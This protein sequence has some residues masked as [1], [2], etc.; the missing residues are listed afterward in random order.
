MFDKRLLKLLPEVRKFIGAAVAGKW[1]ALVAYAAFV[2]G[3]AWFLGLWLDGGATAEDLAWWLAI[4]FGA[5][6]VRF[7][8][9]TGSQYAGSKAS[10]AGKTRVRTEVYDKLI[11]LGPSYKEQVATAQAAQIC[12]EGVEKLEVYL[13]QYLP[14][15]FYAVLAPLTLFALIAPIDVAAAI[16]L[17]V[18]VPLMPISIVAIMKIA[19]R[20][21]GA[22]WDSYVDLGATFLESI[23]ALTTLKLF[24]ADARK[25]E[26]ID[27]QAEGFRQATMRLLRMQLNSVTVMDL[28]TFGA[29]AV[30]IVVGLLHW[31]AGSITLA[32]ALAIALLSIEFF[33]PMRILGSFFHTAMGAA[34]V[35]DQV[36][37]LLA[38]EGPHKGAVKIDADR[39]EVEAVDLG[40]GYG[41]VSALQGVGFSI[42]DNTFVGI[43]GE[44]GSGKSTL[45]AILDGELLGYTGSLRLNGVELRDISAQSLHSVITHVS[46]ASYIFKGSVRS[47]LMIA[48]RDANDY[49]L[50]R[51]LAQ[52]HLDDFVVEQGGLD[53]PVE[54]GGANLS[55]G[56]RQRLAIARAL[57]RNTPAY[58]FDEATSNVDADSEREILACI[59]RLSLEK[60]VIVVSHRL[61]SI[62]WAD[63]IL[64][65]KQG[66][67]VQQGTHGELAV[68]PGHYRELWSQQEQ[69]E[70]LAQQ[71]ET[72]RAA[73]SKSDL[74]ADV[75][76]PEGMSRA[77]EKMPPNIAAATRSVMKGARI[78]SLTEGSGS[79][80]PYGHPADIPLSDAASADEDAA[81]EGTSKPSS[82]ESARKR[83][84][85]G[86]A[87]GL[88]NLCG[89]LN[90]M[91]AWATVLGGLGYGAAIAMFVV[92]AVVLFGQGDGCFTWNSAALLVAIVVCGIVRGF[93][94][95]GERLVSHDQ[96]FRVLALIRSRVFAHMRN[97]APAR[98]ESRDAGDL[99]ALLT[100]DIEL[101][102]V[103]YAHTVSPVLVAVF[104]SLAIV[105]GISMQQPV[106]GLAAL[107]VYCITGVALPAFLSKLST[108]LGYQ[109]KERTVKFSSFMYESLAGLTETL[110]F[111]AEDLRR[112]E[113]GGRMGALA[114]NEA[115][116]ARR[117]AFSNAF[118][119]AL[120]SLCCIAF[121]AVAFSLVSR[122][123][124]SSGCA[125]VCVV[126]LLVSF[127][128][129]I[130]VARLGSSLHQTIASGA[131]VLDFMDER[132]ATP[133]NEQGAAPTNFTGARLRDVSF[134]Y[135]KETILKN[136]SVGIEPESF[137]HVAGPSGAGKSTFLKLLMR[138][139][140]AQQGSV[141]VSGEE[142]RTM[143]TS[144][145]RNLEG[146]MT[147]DTHL[148]SGTIRENIV[149][150][151]PEATDEQL[152]RAV[153]C[154]SLSRLIARL[155]R[156]L[157]TPLG[158]I[159]EGLSQGERQRIG[160]ARIFL[161][162]APFLLLDE[163]TSNLDCLN[164]AMVLSALQEARAGKTIVMVSHRMSAAAFAD[165]TLEVNF[166][167]VS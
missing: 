7:L 94:R 139:W 113:L 117:S 104:V 62:A 99:I 66:E 74:E 120:I 29:A 39:F 119:D 125:A 107:V 155:P 102:E 108:R 15:L 87:K 112:D 90:G 83:S 42:E 76:V 27:K 127:D 57:L 146:A 140:D 133:E 67:L 31:Q 149:F 135:G 32:Q 131:R 26:E 4:S 159:G 10:A 116:L 101:L 128:P 91:V 51:A 16:V 20:V 130:A 85:L 55:G 163:P 70:L 105:V 143:K 162:D 81:K 54:A 48:N 106:L 78:R 129:I 68:R 56:Q 158:E 60:T 25:Q 154:A 84:V 142:V 126:A 121:A 2:G 80:A 52:C 114:K 13:G 150:V 18:C 37:D 86:V 141:E 64:V 5:V 165:T 65:L 152:D 111:G 14:Q 22:Y 8:G 59:Q 161:Y 137:V 132:P 123:A 63:N 122:G 17:L 69:I 44:S 115:Q 156:G 167:R 38:L 109:L 3:L 33:L 36:F 50:W 124:L 77:L 138:V 136:F 71:A 153:R 166:G 61:S 35:L 30:G 164:E 72:V 23:S 34:P 151:R 160:L 79:S 92:A 1:I 144:A 9:Q 96:T 58:L 40:Y 148:F 75:S 46:S 41:E 134:S 28:F 43:T 97:L 157:D 145:L 12:G 110:R 53:M 89:E 100:G 95:Y 45:A 49:E 118:C 103:F 11:A 93:L 147:Q 82:C 19:K 47:N 24:Q 73:Y 98:L 6:A 88:L 21:M